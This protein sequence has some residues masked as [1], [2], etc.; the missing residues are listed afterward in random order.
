M[1]ALRRPFLLLAML[2]LVLAVGVEVGAGLLLGGSDAGAALAGSAADLGVEV[3]DVSGV[4]EPS[5]RGT[6]YLALVDAAALWTTGLFCLGLVLPERIHGRVQGVATLIFSIVLIIVAILAL[7]IAFVELSIMVSLFLAPPFGTLAYLALWGFFPVGDSAVLLGL[8][9]LLK[10]AW[11]G[12]L[13][14]AQPKFIQNKGLVLLIGT[15][16]LCT[17]VLEF[18]HHLV[19]VILVS[20]LDDLGAI[21]FAVIAIIWALVLLIGAI[22]A[23]VKAIHATAALR[24]EPDPHR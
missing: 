4:S 8:V 14:L 10:L 22:P 9:L 20:I 18:L 21:V 5:G 15:S 7:V 17:V 6:G 2:A 16:L 11:A 3:S 13:L 19:P 1:G 12:L 24:A 23:I